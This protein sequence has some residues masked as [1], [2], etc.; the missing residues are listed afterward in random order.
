MEKI[1]LNNNQN[2]IIG[3]NTSRDRAEEARE[4]NCLTNTLLFVFFI[5]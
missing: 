2:K 4:Y 3:I 5:V 1:I